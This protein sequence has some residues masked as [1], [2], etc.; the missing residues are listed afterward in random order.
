MIL[1]L[2]LTIL[3]S[4]FLYILYW[5]GVLSPSRENVK[6]QNSHLEIKDNNPV[7]INPKF[8]D[9]F[10]SKYLGLSGLDNDD[11]EGLII[12][13]SKNSNIVTMRNMKFDIVIFVIKNQEVIEKKKMKAPS[14]RLEYYITYDIVRT[15]GCEYILEL[16]SDHYLEEDIEIGDSV[17]VDIC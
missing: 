11:T 14:N 8:A 15:E 12:E 9:T 7:Q 1:Q 5:S 4:A 16:P 6:F 3:I 2:A 17:V 13:G 10:W